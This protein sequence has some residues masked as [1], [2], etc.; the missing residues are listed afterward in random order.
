ML[1]QYNLYS[2]ACWTIKGTADCATRDRNHRQRQRYIKD[3]F[4]PLDPVGVHGSQAE[5]STDEDALVND[6][7]PAI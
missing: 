2:E 3:Q 5:E 7:D 6:A 1:R 4:C